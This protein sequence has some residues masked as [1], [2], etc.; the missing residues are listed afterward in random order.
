MGRAGLRIGLV[1]LHLHRVD[2]VGELDGVLDE[3]DR[4]VVAD[5]IEIALLGVKLDSEASNIS[6][7]VY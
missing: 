6:G 4:N 5:Q 7:Q 1:G 2:Q 3:E